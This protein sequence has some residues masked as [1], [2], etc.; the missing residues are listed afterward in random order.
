MYRALVVLLAVAACGGTTTRVRPH[1]P[2][3]EYVATIVIEGNHAIPSDDLIPGLA[4]ERAAT[5]AR[6]WAIDDY[7]L[8]L[9]GQRI[10][11]AYQ[12]H[13]FFSVQV[14][15]R[16]EKDGDA[17]T[18]IFHVTEGPRA[19]VQVELTGLPP[20]VSPEQARATIA[21][22]D[23]DPFDYETFD[24]AKIPLTRLVEDA[25]YAHVQLDAHVLA[26]RGNHRAVLRY[27][28]DP[29]P[30]STFGAVT[31]EG[32]EPGMLE[33]A[34]RDRLA[35]GE[36]EPFSA[37]ALERT[38]KD[39]YAA[40]LFTNVRVDADRDVAGGVIPVT[41][42]VAHGDLNQASAGI[43]FGIDP[44]TKYL[45][46]KLQYTRLRFPTPLSTLGFDLRPEYAFENCGWDLWSC[47]PE[48]RG[49][50]FARL[51][52]QD[53]F[54]RDVR[55]DLQVG[56]EY[57]ILEAF[58]RFGPRADAGVT[59][60]VDRW[61]KL[62]VGWQYSY[63]D[64]QDFKIDAAEA[65][66]LGANHP[67]SVGAYTGAL[68]LDLRDKPI[69]PREGIYAEV[70]GQLGTPFAGGAFNYTEIVPELRLFHS[71]GKTTFAARAR[72]GRID[73]DVP[74]IERFF[75]GGVSSHRGFSPRHLSPE[76]PTTRLPIGGAGLMESSF[77]IRRPLF[78]PWGFDLGGVAFV[79]AGDV[80]RTFGELDPTNPHVAVG[81]ALGWFSPIGPVGISVARRVNR[82]GPDE[83]EHGHKWNWELV[84]GEA[85]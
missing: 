21:L 15:T 84:V 2:G 32:A 71:I 45:R 35:F 28:L 47:T 44:L 36:G 31:I 74:V 70:R 85:F 76:D 4:L 34:V 43:G 41:V 65:A 59:L 75:G 58:T 66:S 40:G 56:Y 69:E 61:V 18:V 52:Q 79:D 48:L 37:S 73:G 30:R 64:F 67:N 23:G 24:D 1:T 16:I 38:R 6:G 14:K 12:K 39:L 53:L 10:A 8:V 20:E 54:R 49:R 55:G 82:T 63:M 26:D 3:V 51:T 27:V 50:L 5:A 13:G 83:P 7:Q 72:V 80:T 81:A 33:Q 42:T 60:P 57:L 78:S 29:G 19:T 22:Q 9:D 68:I 17:A 11:A 77:E 25:G 46:V 62:R